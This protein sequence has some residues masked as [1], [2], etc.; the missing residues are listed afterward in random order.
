MFN[1]LITCKPGNANHSAMEKRLSHPRNREIISTDKSSNSL[2][3]QCFIKIHPLGT[4]FYQHTPTS[5]TT[6]SFLYNMAYTRRDPKVSK[7]VLVFSTLIKYYTGFVGSESQKFLNILTVYLN[8][9]A[10]SALDANSIKTINK[11]H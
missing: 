11:Q 10:V 7:C 8:Y 6:S 5:R 1:L 9:F 2:N 4:A 3:M